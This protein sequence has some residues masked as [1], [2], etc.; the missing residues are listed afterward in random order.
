MKACGCGAAYVRDYPGQTACRECEAKRP[1][2]AD[3]E[4]V[5]E[6]VEELAAEWECDPYVSRE[7]W[8]VKVCPGCNRAARVRAVLTL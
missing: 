6:R 1:A 7:E 2:L 3:V 4:L 8:H 5:R